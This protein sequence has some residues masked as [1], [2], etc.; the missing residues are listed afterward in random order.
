MGVE[1]VNLSLRQLRA[2]EAVARLRSFAAAAQELHLTPAALSDSVRQL[3]AVLGLRL[4]D[5]TT[6][7]VDTSPAGVEFLHDARATLQTLQG[8]V[9]RLHELRSLA[10]GRVRVAAAPSV[11]A[12]LVVPELGAPASRGLAL[13]LREEGADGIVRLV[14]AGEVDFGVGGL[15]P[16]ESGVEQQPLLRDRYGLVAPPGHALLRRRRLTLA[17]LDGAAFVGLT[18]DTAIAQVLAAHPACPPAVRDTAVR[19]SN[20]GLLRLMIDAGHG[21]SALPALVARHPAFAGL[22]FRPFDDAEPMREVRMVRRPGRSLSPAAQAL[23]DALQRR[24]RAL[25]GADGIEAA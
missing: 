18:P 17:A 4:L 2:F 21:I 6:R 25:A 8:A 16:R 13:T 10:R 19:V 12:C 3:E 11:L 7:H 20:P 23:W 14:K 24:A 1:L 15:P 5:R 22:A 9:E